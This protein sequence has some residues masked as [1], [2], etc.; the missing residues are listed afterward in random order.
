[1]IPHTQQF[2]FM[3]RGL[4]ETEAALRDKQVSSFVVV[5]KKNRSLVATLSGLIVVVPLPLASRCPW[6]FS[7]APMRGRPSL[8]SP[9]ALLRRRRRRLLLLLLLLRLQTMSLS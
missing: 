3:L 4:R 6:F 9:R 7:E 1:M 2:G 5:K 8:C